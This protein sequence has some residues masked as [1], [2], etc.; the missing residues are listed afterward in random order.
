MQ[1]E[2]DFEVFKTL[3]ALRESE[4]DSYNAVIRKLLNLPNQNALNVL[5]DKVP[6]NAIVG[7]VNALATH[8]T[9]RGIFGNRLPTNA[10][11]KDGSIGGILA[12]YLQGAW[13]GNTHFPEE[14]KFRATY[15]GQTYYAQIKDGAWLGQDNVVR[16]SPSDAASAISGTNV[17]GWKFWHAQHPDDPSWRRLDEF[18]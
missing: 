1:I 2:I 3:T 13:F 14:T 11:A 7:T 10:L 15:K 18:R 9:K 4:A 8:P 12:R 6:P 16:T 5:L 17:N